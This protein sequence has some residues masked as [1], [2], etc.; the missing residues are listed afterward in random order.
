MVDPRLAAI[1]RTERGTDDDLLAETHR[2]GEYPR[3]ERRA[4]DRGAPSGDVPRTARDDGG[5]VLGVPS[6]TGSMD[7][8]TMLVIGHWPG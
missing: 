8:H 5:G 3:H 6:W 7:G 2:T 4:A 1:L